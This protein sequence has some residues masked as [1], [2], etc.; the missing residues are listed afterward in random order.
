MFIAFLPDVFSSRSCVSIF[1]HSGERKNSERGKAFIAKRGRAWRADRRSLTTSQWPP[2]TYVSTIRWLTFAA[3]CTSFPCI[4][5]FHSSSW[6]GEFGGQFE[7]EVSF[8]VTVTEKL[9]SRTS[10]FVTPPPLPSAAHLGRRFSNLFSQTMLRDEHDE[11]FDR[12]M[13]RIRVNRE[14]GAASWLSM[15]PSAETAHVEAAYQRSIVALRSLWSTRRVGSP[16]NRLYL[17]SPIPHLC[18]PSRERSSPIST[19]IN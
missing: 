6:R 13:K 2:C 11:P 18:L 15:N 17:M 9:S 16:D 5:F 19:T 3:A 14:E 10:V 8:F 1:I 7:L 12:M 4:R